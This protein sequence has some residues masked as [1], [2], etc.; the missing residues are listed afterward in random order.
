M[1]S[2]GILMPISS[3]ASPY[4]IGTLGNEAYQFIDFL[5]AA[6]QKYWQILPLGPTSYGDSPY[7]SFS[8]FAGNPYFIDLEELCK[9]GLLTKQECESQDWGGN[10]QYVDYQKMFESRNPLLRK[11]YEREKGGSALAEFR[12]RNTDWLE[13]YALYMALKKEMKLKAWNEWNDDI[14]LRKPSALTKYREKLRSEIDF[15]V[16]LQYLFFEQWF[17][18]KKYA[19]ENGIGIIGDVPIY[20]ALDSADAWANS[21]IFMLDENKQPTSVAGC[22]P[23]AFTSTGQLW[24]NPIYRWDYLKENQYGWWVQRLRASAALHDITRI[25]HFRGFESYYVIPYGDKTAENG[26][27]FKGPGMDF[28]DIIKEK[29]GHVRLIAEDLGY[30][31]SEVYEMREKSGYPGMKVLEFAFDS[32]ESSDYLPHN[33]TKNCVV[34]TGTH[35]NDTVRGWFHTA[36]PQDIKL[37]MRYMNITDPQ[38]GSWAFIR[39]A[40]ASV[41]DMAIVQ[42]QDFLDLDSSC[43]MNTPSTVGNNWKWRLKSGVLNLELAEKIEALAKLYGR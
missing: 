23:D 21:E 34:Y 6:G 33:Y 11:A 22:P 36:N 32:R 29:L 42:M 30:L 37:A 4:G 28:F 18:L 9:N 31:T 12:A 41:A 26:Q 1:R 16:Y 5:K 8:V 25:D 7:Q 10:A 20:V 38:D 27:W 2:S 17:K 14:K 24:G 19:N 13:D 40:Y 39:T 15:N 43:R 3:L 35:D